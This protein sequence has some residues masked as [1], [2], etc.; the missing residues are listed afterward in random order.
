MFLTYSAALAVFPLGLRPQA[1]AQSHFAKSK[2][3]R[4]KYC[5]SIGR[6]FQFLTMCERLRHNNYQSQL[7]LFAADTRASHF[8]SLENSAALKMKGISGQ[9]CLDLY[10]ASGRDGSFAKMLLDTFGS[11]STRLPH[12]WKLKAT[13]S[14]RLLFQ[15]APLMPHTGGTEFGLLATPNTMDCLPPR[16]PESLERQM[17]TSRKGRKNLANLRDQLVYGVNWLPTPRATRAAK[18]GEGFGITLTQALLPT[19][20]TSDAKGASA[21]RFNGSAHSH[22]NLREVLRSGP[23]AGQYPHPEFVEYMMGYPTGHSDL[24]PSATPLSLKSPT[25]LAKQ[26]CSTT[27]SL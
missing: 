6:T 25:S 19:P 17:T 23:T 18:A 24:K 12:R 20:S 7:T 16:S 4:K 9:R 26:S 8:Q 2:N 13:S 10:K 21:K 14:G 3:T 27:G 22:G 5:A 15:L 11:V 1:C